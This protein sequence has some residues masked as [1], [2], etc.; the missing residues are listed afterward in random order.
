MRLRYWLAGTCAQCT[1]SF[2]ATFG[3]G[4]M[5][6]TPCR[7]PSSRHSRRFIRSMRGA[8]S[9]PGSTRLPATLRAIA[10]STPR[11]G[12]MKTSRKYNEYRQ[13]QTATILQRHSN[14]RNS[15]PESQRLSKLCRNGNE[16]RSAFMILK[17]SP[18]PKYRK[19]WVSAAVRCE[20]T[21]TTR[22]ERFGSDSS[23][24]VRQD[25]L[26]PLRHEA[27]NW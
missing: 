8:R 25:E 21:C 7:R 10:G 22:G 26:E 18:R 13:R 5:L 24:C 27:R 14:S 17:A 2:P 6:T 3:A 9:H 12:I 11:P 23:D 16:P 4:R 1:L 19:C 15:G 20:P